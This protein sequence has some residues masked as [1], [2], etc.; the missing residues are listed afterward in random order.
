MEDSKEGMKMESLTNHRSSSIMFDPSSIGFMELLGLQELSSAS[1]FDSIL[2]APWMEDPPPSSS[3]APHDSS[4]VLNLPTTPNSSSISSA[5]NEAA[6]T[7]DDHQHLINNRPGRQDREEEEDEQKKTMKQWKPKK[8][9]L[10]RQREPR[11]AFM[12]KSEVDHLEDGYRWR[13]YGQKAV[14]NSPFPRSYYRCTTATCNVKKRV[15]RCFNDP[16]IVVTTYEGQ[17]R[18]PSP[19][20]TRAGYP[21]GVLP[22][23]GFSTGITA[24][25]A[26]PMQMASVS[27]SNCFQHPSYNNNM[28][29]CFPSWSF[30]HVG[31][32]GAGISNTPQERSLFTPTSTGLLRDD[33]LLQ[34]IV[35]RIIRK[36]KE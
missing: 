19:V 12:T 30:N 6:T 34:D 9:N 13:K 22:D 20:M 14:K 28:N 4:D 10:K 18:H 17:H 2:Q 3:T 35:P 5:S 21:I 16:S 15:E 1:F 27:L 25:S 23:S 11:F 29:G 26:A 33:G 32:R 8:T 31:L 36:E 7:N 24:T